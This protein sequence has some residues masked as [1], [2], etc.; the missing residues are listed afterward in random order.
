MAS[1]RLSV[2]A[3]DAAAMGIKASDDGLPG[4]RP[5]YHFNYYAAFVIEE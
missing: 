1:D 5:Q 4:L 3:F 2:D